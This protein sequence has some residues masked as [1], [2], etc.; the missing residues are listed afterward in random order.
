MDRKG[1][2]THLQYTATQGMCYFSPIL[3]G[4]YQ[5]RFYGGELPSLR[6]NC[7]E[8]NHEG[9][10]RLVGNAGGLN[11]SQQN[12]RMFKNSCSTKMSNCFKPLFNTYIVF[13]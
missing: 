5:V 1:E 7:Q 12:Y 8:N 9:Q 6:F 11:S 10:C 4:I 3:L 2:K 13:R